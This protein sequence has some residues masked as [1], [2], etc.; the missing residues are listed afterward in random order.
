MPI[1]DPQNLFVRMLSDVRRREERTKTICQE[2]SK[3][4]EDPDIKETLESWVFIEDKVLS[5]IDQCFKLIGKSPVETRGRVHDMVVEEFRSTLSEIQHPLAKALYVA[6]T[7]SRVMHL[8][9]GEYVALT[10]MAD[11]SGHYGVGAL[12]ETC[13]ADNLAYVERLRRGIRNIIETKVQM[14]RAA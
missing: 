6:S 11:L 7:A 5:T 10:A 3:V 1:A 8:H 4:A 14:R 9:I 13:L 12:L 2:L